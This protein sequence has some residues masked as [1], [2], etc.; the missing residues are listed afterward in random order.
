VLR[1]KIRILMVS[2]SPSLNYRY[3][4]VALKNDPAID[5]LSFIILRTPS[6]IMNVPLQEQSLIP[7]PVD[8]LFS[9]EL[10]NFDLLIFDNFSYNLFLRKT[11]LESIERFVKEGGGFAAIGGPQFLETNRLLGSAL[12][13]MVPVRMS[14]KEFY[15][16]G[17]SF[18]VKLS[19]GG[20]GHPITRFSAEEN[21]NTRFWQEMPSLN[22]MNLVDSKGSAKV[23]LESTGDLS[24]PILTV[25]NYGGGRTL[26]LATDDSWKWY[27]GMVAQGKGNWAY[28]RFMERMVRWLTRDPSLDPVQVAWMEGETRLGQRKEFRIQIREAELPP[29][30][31]GEMK[32][33]VLNP[34]GLQMDA[35]L[36][37]EG[38][39]QPNEFLGSFIPEKEGIYKLKIE[40]PGGSREENVLITETWEDQDGIPDHEQLK[41][42]AVLTGGRVLGKGDDPLKVIERVAKKGEKHFFEETK[43]PLW[44]NFYALALILVLL[45][46]EWYFR[47]RWGLH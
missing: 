23:L 47:R 20:K 33:T 44:G 34:D 15:R 32:L 12:E 38:G 30:S 10:K 25:G 40:T 19:R 29:G 7:F 43:V 41:R 17:S 13:E 27:M 18:G 35:R 1:D 2:G 37:E 3:L 31:K 4:R 46:S 16:R 11:H 14:G 28:L 6:D 45:T 36:E 39:R 22:G 21:S 42:I 24:R 26:A 9:K 5:L 8:T